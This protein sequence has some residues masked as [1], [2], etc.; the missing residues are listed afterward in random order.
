MA[1][2][3]I[4]P[5]FMPNPVPDIDDYLQQYE[6]DWEIVSH[7]ETSAKSFLAELNSLEPPPSLKDPRKRA[8]FVA[9]KEV[10]KSSAVSRKS[11]EKE[12]L[13]ES[14][15]PQHARGNNQHAL[16]TEEPLLA[17]NNETSR[18]VLRGPDAVSSVCTSNCTVFGFETDYDAPCGE[19]EEEEHGGY[20]V[21]GYR[22]RI[23]EQR[24]CETA[25]RE[26]QKAEGK[27]EGS[28]AGQKGEICEN[29]IETPEL[30]M[31]SVEH[32]KKVSKSSPS[33]SQG[34]VL[35][36][37]ICGQYMTYRFLT[38]KC[39]FSICSLYTKDTSEN[40]KGAGQG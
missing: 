37:C 15:V 24:G 14:G 3:P 33:A 13:C 16:L 1:N 23:Q 34:S 5:S 32:E 8:T 20:V 10:E 36:L 21:D 18:E 11:G 29:A 35:M 38:V 26:A 27:D 40:R 39:Q 31:P 9:N 17:C 25:A 22:Q 7:S 12:E 4:R 19:E 28:K 30:I 2:L 6:P